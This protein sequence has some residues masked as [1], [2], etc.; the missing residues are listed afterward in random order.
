MHLLANLEAAS[1]PCLEYREVE[2]VVKIWTV[3]PN[4]YAGVARLPLRY[5]SSAKQN[6]VG[7]CTL[8][9]VVWAWLEGQHARNHS[10]Y[11]KTIHKSGLPKLYIFLHH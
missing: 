5:S 11:G 3:Q 2:R 1:L 7:T 4:S 10:Q 6:G 9:G 8:C